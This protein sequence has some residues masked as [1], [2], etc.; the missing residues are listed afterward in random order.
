MCGWTHENHGLWF[1]ISCVVSRWS[2]PPIRIVNR[3]HRSVVMT[4]GCVSQSVGWIHR[5]DPR[6]H[7]LDF[8]KPRLS[9]D[10]RIR[11]DKP[12]VTPTDPRVMTTRS[13]DGVQRS[14][15]LSHISMG[16]HKPQICGFELRIHGSNTWHCCHNPW[17]KINEFLIHNPRFSWV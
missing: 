13:V 16:W 10:S 7:G 15:G 12:W 2:N 5:S 8:R 3:K 4:Y 14:V 6:I 11:C 17:H 9:C 1:K